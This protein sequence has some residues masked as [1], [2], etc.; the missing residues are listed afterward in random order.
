MID[1]PLDIDLPIE[2]VTIE[3]EQNVGQFI[4]STTIKPVVYEEHI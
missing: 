1:L 3:A 2:N 4:N